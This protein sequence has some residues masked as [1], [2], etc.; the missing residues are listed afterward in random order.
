MTSQRASVSVYLSG[1]E[2]TRAAYT[3]MLLPPSAALGRAGS[4]QAAGEVLAPGTS[5]SLGGTAWESCVRLHGSRLPTAFALL[6]NTDFTVSA[7]SGA[8]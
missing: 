5:A 2:S 7:P 4:R 3:C 6:E 1:N 8:V